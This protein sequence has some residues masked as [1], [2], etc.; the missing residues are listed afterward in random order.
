[1]HDGGGHS[2]SGSR[3]SGAGGSDPSTRRDPHPDLLDPRGPMGM[4][5]IVAR[6]ADRARR[7]QQGLGI[8]AARIFVL[9]VFAIIA[10]FAILFIIHGQ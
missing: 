10:A 9:S 1:M 5:K 8:V 3:P 4:P 2:G 6:A 7:G